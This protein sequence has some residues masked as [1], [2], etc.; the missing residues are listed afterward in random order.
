M[1]QTQTK[2]GVAPASELRRAHPEGGWGYTACREGTM[3]PQDRQMSE[4]PSAPSQVS[5]SL[6]LAPIPEP[7]TVPVP[8]AE[9]PRGDS[10]S[11]PAPS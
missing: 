8:Q 10:G 3:L 11:F 5:Q 2:P 6:P 1:R 4:W 7:C 9:E